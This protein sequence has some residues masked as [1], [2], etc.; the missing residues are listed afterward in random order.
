VSSLDDDTLT[1]TVYLT[2]NY[3]N[4]G[5]N[6][7]DNVN[8]D[9]S[10]FIPESITVTVTGP[11]SPYS[12]NGVYDKEG[13]LNEGRPKYHYNDGEWDY[14]IYWNGSRWELDSGGILHYHTSDTDIPPTE[15]W[16]PTD[17]PKNGEVTSMSITY[18]SI[19]TSLVL[20]ATGSASYIEAG[21]Y[22]K[23]HDDYN[24]TGKPRY[25]YGS[26]YIYYDGSKWVVE[27]ATFA[28]HHKVDSSTSP[29]KTG[30]TSNDDPGNNTEITLTY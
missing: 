20:N 1:L 5:V 11:Y 15:G 18:S 26:W 16:T 19:P 8:K 17:E 21:T 22:T 12:E 9:T 28:F 3:D 29:P 13:A 2:D 7:T 4:Q 30:W 27:F 10:V 6:A 24:S 14:D 25:A 23:T